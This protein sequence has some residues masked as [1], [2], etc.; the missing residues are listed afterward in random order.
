[1][2]LDNTE[3][4]RARAHTAQGE[5]RTPLWQHMAALYPPFVDYQNNTER[6]IPVVVLERN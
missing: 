6:E 3:L 1:M 2:C 4:L 5:E